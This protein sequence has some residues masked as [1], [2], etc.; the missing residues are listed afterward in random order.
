MQT[1]IISKPCLAQ[2]PQGFTV[3]YN[4]RFLYSKY[5]PSRVI[6]QTIENL[7]IQ[8]GTL[9]LCNSPALNYGLA[10]LSAKLPEKCF[11]LL[12]EADGELY[13]FESQNLE[14][15][16]KN[17]ARITLKELQNLPFLLQ[18]PE[19]TFANGKS[20]PPAGTFRRVI[21]LDF[22]AGVQFHAE[23]YD[24]VYQATTAAIKTF[25]VNR[26]TLNKFGRRYS[27]NF[28]S[29]LKKLPQTTPIQNYF[30][31]IE[32]PILVLGA[33]E[34]LNTT[35]KDLE[36]IR[37]NFFIL[38]ADTAL[39]ACITRQIT[40]D[41][42]FIEEAQSVITKAFIG[43]LKGDFQ[44]FAGLSSIPLLSKIYKPQ[45]ISYFTTLYTN[46]TFID[47]LSKQ[48]LLPPQNEPMGSV[49]LTAVYYALKFRKSVNIPVIVSGLDFSYTA[50]TTHAK[51]TMAHKT[52]LFSN[53]R[54]QPVQNYAA[55]Y[56]EAAVTFTDIT[57]N[58]MVTTPTLQGYANLFNNLF[59]SEENLYDAR[60][61]GIKL[62]IPVTTL[63]S[64]TLLSFANNKSISK[65]E[66][67]DK[68]IINK[69]ELETFFTNEH[70]TLETLRDILSGKAKL[71]PDEQEAKIRELAI[72]RE[73]LYLHF[74]DGQTFAYTKPFLNRLRAEIDF[75]LK[76]I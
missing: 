29:N 52:R 47:L 55:A 27:R 69:L 11:M 50:G 10:E 34:S 31:K 74:P 38:C 66:T 2:T 25:W 1:N 20:L 41:G 59:S 70:K 36:P 9:F 68:N 72:P 8:P 46:A 51:G 6:I 17:A 35:L 58:Q 53:T 45:Q 73:Y 4:E 60:T 63:S 16:P 3:S 49:G 22:S 65:P 13:E 62:N 18:K 57:G 43:A 30:G 48:G 14:P 75:F 56:S 19:Y 24:Q 5:N 33:G 54:L 23:Y 67:S 61:C 28:F 42:V 12:C 76:Y 40:P 39:Q 21:R 37:S 26:I 15:L 44:L 32:K 71:P 64:K 7:T